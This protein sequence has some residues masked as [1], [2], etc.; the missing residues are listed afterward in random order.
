MKATHP[1]WQ[2]IHWCAIITIVG[3]V[4]RINATSFD[5]TEINS[6]VQIGAAL[7]AVLTGQSWLAKRGDHGKEPK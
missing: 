6:L 2:T 1:F 3:V 7:A 5:E 4:L